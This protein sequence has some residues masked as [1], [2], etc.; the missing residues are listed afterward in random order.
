MLTKP[1]SHE[2]AEQAQITVSPT[3]PSTH[4]A[5]VIRFLIQ[6]KKHT[7]QATVSDHASQEKTSSAPIPSLRTVKANASLSQASK[8]NLLKNQKTNQTRETEHIVFSEQE[9]QDIPLLA[10]CISFIMKRGQKAKAAR[11]MNTVLRML[12]GLSPQNNKDVHALDMIHTA[13]QN[14]KPAF[15]LRKARF[16]GRTQFI[17][18][19]LPVHKQENQALRALVQTARTK[20]QKASYTNKHHDMYT[21]AYFLAQEIYDAYKHQGAA[22]QAKHGIHK[23]AEHNRNHVRRRWW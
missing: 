12:Q 3:T 14:V 21:F 6:R 22:C 15:E 19:T 8:Q 1:F 10:K 16:G 9:M 4:A 7:P 13:I 20:H 2:W 5:K 17:P 11:T 18:A 23:Q